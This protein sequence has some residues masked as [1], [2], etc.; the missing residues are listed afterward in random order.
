MK[1][2]ASQKAARLS[3]RAKIAE[4]AVK[5]AGLSLKRLRETLVL[6][7]FDSAPNHEQAHCWICRKEG[8]RIPM[9]P[10]YKTM[11]RISK[12]PKEATL[13]DV[14]AQLPEVTILRRPRRGRTYA[15]LVF[16]S[17]QEARKALAL[18]HVTLFK[19]KCP[20]SSQKRPEPELPKL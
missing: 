4:V 10:S 1:Y 2:S 5:K 19:K 15:F 13:Q 11:L 9:C 7:D 20:L 3:K 14:Q 12:L 8:H 18:G 6:G 17:F 16:S